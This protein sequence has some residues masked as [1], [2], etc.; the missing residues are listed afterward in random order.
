MPGTQ[1]LAR[2]TSLV[3]GAPVTIAISL[4]AAL[5]GLPSSGTAQPSSRV[6]YL[7]D[8][9]S[10]TLDLVDLEAGAA[11][12]G[13]LP[14]GVVPNQIEIV[15][16]TAYV[17]NSVPATLQVVDLTGPSTV[18]A[19]D[20]GSGSNPWAVAIAGAKAYVSLWAADQV[21]VVDLTTMTVKHKIAVGI[22]PEGLCLAG[23]ELYVANSGFI[24]PGNHAPGTVSVI[25]IDTDLVTHTIPVGLNAQWCATDGEGE[26]HVV[27]SDLFAANNG[28]VFIVDPAVHAAVDSL[29]IGG[30]PGPI[31]IGT[32]GI[33]WITEYG[34]G[35][36]AVDTVAHTVRNDVTNPVDAGGL[37][38]LGL[39]LDRSDRIY[40][41]VSADRLLTVLDPDGALADAYPVGPGALDVAIFEERVTPVELQHWTAERQGLS[42][43]L[44]WSIQGDPVLHCDVE[45]SIVGGKATIAYPAPIS[46]ES[47]R[48]S[49]LDE[50]AGPEAI[51]YRIVAHT[52]GGRT[53][54]VGT[55]PVP[56][57]VATP[58]NAAL[59][60]QL[61][62][63][64][65]PNPSAG[66]VNF[67][68]RL[69][70]GAPA[71]GS[72]AEI[73]LFDMRGR[74][75]RVLA[76][77]ALAAGSPI[78]WDGRD[79]AGRP[80]SSGLYLARLRGSSDVAQKIS[81]VR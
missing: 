45:R 40:V 53:E 9:A 51:R 59:A 30:F 52:R 69:A 39:D 19:V 46:D 60:G 22:R 81:I 71:A 7:V 79:S 47:G 32:N 27:C 11:Q 49:F 75:V 72:I 78:A 33:G 31:E 18:T 56:A 23:R 62:I 16:H 80:V 66:P 70:N 35:L 44:A 26:V 10:Q 73:L 12:L 24:G 77:R 58:S 41:A 63:H 5:T 13:I 36:L 28:R 6:A 61:R 57:A 64:A 38:A 34:A 43:E 37:G 76:P 1:V 15:G 2:L 67:E 25:D 42:V 50:G 17:V 20:L 68:L 14:V 3:C 54:T 21:A 48:F 55:I 65:A 29:W 4:G 74:L 8:F